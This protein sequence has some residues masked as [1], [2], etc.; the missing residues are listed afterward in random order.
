MKTAENL[1]VRRMVLCALFAALTA[2]CSQIAIPMPWAGASC[3][4]CPATS[5]TSPWLR[6]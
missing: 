5:L 2:V 4:P 6:S 3:P 1:R